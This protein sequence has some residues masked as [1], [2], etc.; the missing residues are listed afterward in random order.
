MNQRDHSAAKKKTWG[1][2]KFTVLDMVLI[3][4]SDR[5]NLGAFVLGILAGIMVTMAYWHFCTLWSES[6]SF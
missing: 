1:L 2:K 6:H 4:D 3:Q 5:M